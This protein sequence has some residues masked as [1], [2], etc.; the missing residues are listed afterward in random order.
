MLPTIGT[1]PRETSDDPVALLT[2]C[3]ERIR[4]FTRL[5]VRLADPAIASPDEI[6]EA[7]QGVH[8][9]FSVALPLHVADEDVSIGPRLLAGGKQPRAVREAV[10]NMTAQHVTIDELL[11]RALPLW[12]ALAGTDEAQA[13][14]ARAALEELA[15]RLAVLFDLHLVHEEDTLFP[16]IGALPAEDRAAIVREMRAR[17]GTE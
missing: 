14:K 12:A 6:R 13:E 7:A 9:Y 4:R 3:H 17:R 15:P 11:A 1:K 10:A 5:A 8:R 2:E 16:A